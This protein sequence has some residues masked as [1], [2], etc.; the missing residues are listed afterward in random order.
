VKKRK[1]SYPKPR[2]ANAPVRGAGLQG[3]P[4]R[5]RSTVATINLAVLAGRN[6][7][8]IGDRVRI[9][10]DGLYA[11]EAAT[12]LSLVGGLI[13]AATVQTEAGRTRRVRAVDLERIGPEQRESE[14]LEQAD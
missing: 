9:G 7:L 5:T 2:T 11:G 1:V 3:E 4:A 13:P 8:A 14:T 12:V 6:D 10:G